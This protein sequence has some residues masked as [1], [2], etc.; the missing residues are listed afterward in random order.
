MA[1]LVEYFLSKKYLPKARTQNK[2]WRQIVITSLHG[3]FIFYVWLIVVSLVI[4]IVSA[5]IGF[6]GRFIDM[7]SP[8]RRFL[9][10]IF[11]FWFVMRF[12]RAWESNFIAVVNGGGKKTFQDS[13]SVNAI[14]QL[15]RVIA[16]IVILLMILSTA[17]IK[18]STLLAFGGIGGLALSFAAK[19][20]LA[21]FIGG[22]MIYW[23]RPFSVGDWVSSPDRNIEG[24]VINI[25]WRLT[26]IRTFDKRPLYVP[27]AAFS[28]I[29]VE[30]PSR[31][32]NRRIKT[33]V[34]IRYNDS[35]KVSAIVDD[36]TKMLSEHPEIDTT[37]TLFV[38][39]IEFGSSSLNILIY[40]FTKTT[41]WVKFQTVQEDVFLKMIEIVAKH[42]AQFAFPTSTI[43]I[44]QGIETFNKINE[45]VDEPRSLR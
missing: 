22:L 35:A 5:K 39:L 41:E 19:D 15:F 25:G 30:N 13:T 34:G 18:I 1:T 45:D 12:I 23:D 32:L 20:T 40:T 44:P 14:A 4:E 38:R 7:I 9:T 11:L 8:V 3:P 36:I 24:T 26:A 16:I 43:E 27:N 17:G 29:S 42:G 33:V 2:R 6:N 21:N 31:M 37:Q 28:T 10:L